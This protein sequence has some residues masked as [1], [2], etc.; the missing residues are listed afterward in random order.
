MFGSRRQVEALTARVS[1]LEEQVAA[2]SAELDRAR[3]LLADTARLEALTHGAETALAALESRAE[4]LRVPGDRFD[5]RLNTL[6][7]AGTTGFV[8]IYFTTGWNA[9]VELRVGTQP[10][11]TRVVGALNAE[12]Y[13]GGIVRGGEYWVAHA[14]HDR[15]GDSFKV[16]FTPLF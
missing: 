7:R 6:Y 2:L 9:Q 13:A 11:P 8:A 4:P 14:D 10:P 12:G 1:A 5:G 15:A 16:H 3:P